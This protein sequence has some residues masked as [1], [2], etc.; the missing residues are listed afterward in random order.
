MFDSMDS[1]Y[2]DSDDIVADDA[3]FDDCS[4]DVDCEGYDLENNSTDTSFD[5]FDEN[6][7]DGID[8]NSFEDIVDGQMSLFDDCDIED[9]M[10]DVIDDVDLEDEEFTDIVD[11][12]INTVEGDE[13][14]EQIEGQVDIEEYF[15]YR[16][17][18]EHTPSYDNA[19]GHWEDI[20]GESIFIPNEDTE[21]H[22]I[23]AALGLNGIP[24]KEGKP[25]FSSV[26]AANILLDA[27]DMLLSD[28]AQKEMAALTLADDIDEEVEDDEFIDPLNE[29]IINAVL[30]ETDHEDVYAALFSG[31]VP[32]DFVFHHGEA[33][34]EGEYR[35]SLLPRA[36]HDVC[37]HRG[38]RSHSGTS[39]NGSN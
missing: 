28:A 34:E 31:E 12:D 25:D 38:G 21:A 29:D 18:I 22:R 16:E 10:V 32:N 37:R 39:R 20:R 19:S 1:G 17:D 7:F 35:Y 36:I 13:I 8:D 26:S 27:D 30:G 5:F 23:L 6:V 15:D 11:E 9:E 3:S 2:Y 14:D 33:N 4:L 24:Y